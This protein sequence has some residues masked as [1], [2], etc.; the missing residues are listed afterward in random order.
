M[1]RTSSHPVGDRPSLTGY[2]RLWWATWLAVAVPAAAVG[3]LESPIPAI[4]LGAIVLG[5]RLG[6][7][8]VDAEDVWRTGAAAMTGSILL[9]AGASVLGSA[10]LPLAVLACA[11]SVPVVR[12][13]LRAVGA[14][15][16]YP[17]LPTSE[18]PTDPASCLREMTGEE[19]CRLWTISFTVVRSATDTR[20]RVAAA[21]LRA[22][23]LDELERRDHDALAK[24]LSRHPSPAS[25]PRWATSTPPPPFT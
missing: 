2:R 17:E 16:A 5:T 20:R 10:T 21:G 22:R 23:L 8:I 19:L 24:W 25:E 6:C 14:D 12:V 18:W 9:V 15:R 3:V 7:A 13:L 4:V 1:G 11:T